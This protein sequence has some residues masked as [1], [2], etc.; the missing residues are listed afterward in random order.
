MEMHK[1][2]KVQ[3]HVHINQAS[4]S[5]KIADFRAQSISSKEFFKFHIINATHLRQTQQRFY[6]D[7][8][9]KHYHFNKSSRQLF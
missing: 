3:T 6:Y 2:P 7:D 1:V 5:Y 9:S 8:Y 4:Q